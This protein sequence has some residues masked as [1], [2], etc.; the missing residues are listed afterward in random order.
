MS[1]KSRLTLTVSIALLVCLLLS[2]TAQASPPAPGDRVLGPLA[3]D[4][5]VGTSSV[6]GIGKSIDQPNIKDYQRIQE[7]MRLLAAGKDAEA[8]ALAQTADDRVLVILVEFAGTDTF[9]WNAGDTWDPLG[10]ADPNE[11]TGTVG[12]CSKIITQT[13]TFTYSGPLHNQIPRPLSADDRSGDSIWTENFSKDWFNAF[14]WG[15]GI[16]FD[17]TRQDGSKVH[18]DF[19]GESVKQYF[20]DMSGGQY[21]IAGDVIGWV[22][23]PHST[24]YYDAD[25][26]PGA[27]SGA[28]TSRGVIPGAGN[29]RT[30]VKDALD[31]VNAISNTIPGFSW[32]NYDLNGDSVIDRLWIV[33]AGYGEEDG[34]TLLNRTDYGEAAVW[35]HS[36]SVTPAYPVGEGIKAGPYIVMPE[37]GGIGVFAHEYAHNLGADDLYAYG[38]GET[39]AGFWALQADDWTGYPIGY[40]P[41]AV[42]PWHLDGWGWLN[43]KVVKDPSQVYEVTVGQASNFPGGE[44]VYRGV[45]IELPDGESPL[46]VPVWQGQHYWWGGKANLANSGMMTVA[47]IAIP[48]GGASLSFDTAYGI[49]TEWDFMWVQAS[50]DGTTWTTLTNAHTTCTHVSGWVGGN[51]GFPEDL[52]AA[53]IGGL[54]DYNHNFP[55][56]DT[57]VFDLA[58]FAG[59]SILLRFWYMTDWGTTYEGPFVDNVKVMAGANTLFADDAESGDAKWQYGAPWQRSAGM[60]PF[61]HNFY[62]QWRNVGETGGYDASLGDARW[63]FGPVNTG[64]LVWYNNNYYSD[65]EVFNYLTDFPGYGPKGRMLVVD[66]HPEPYRYPDLVAA[67]YN[68]EAGNLT[69]R[70]QMRDATFS[71]KDSITFMNKDPYGWANVPDPQWVQYP[72]R[73]AVSAFHDAWGYYPGAEFVPGGPVG[74]TSNRWMTKQWDASATMP[75]KSFY[76]IKA[77][78]YN[79]TD[80]MRFGCSTNAAGQVLC[81]S[82]AA[83]LGYTGGSGNPGDSLAQYGWHV[84]ILEQTD[85]TAKLRIWNSEWDLAGEMTQTALSSVVT[86]GSDIAVNVKAQN[87]GGMMDGFFFVPIDALTAYE[88][89]SV[90]GGAYPVTAS[91]AAS[92]AAKYGAADLTAPEG[93]AGDTVIG[94]AYEASEFATGGTVDFGFHVIV[95][96]SDGTVRHTATVSSGGKLIGTF[97][98]NPITLAVQAKLD[99]DPTADTYLQSAA[100]AANYGTAAFLH[101]R[102]D[103]AG[104]DILRS[105]LSFDVSS[106]LPAYPVEKAEL[107]VYLDAFSGGA[108]DGQLQAYEVT[109]AWAENTAT[110]KTPWVKPGGD[111]AD[112]AVAGASLDKSMVGK[113][114]TIDVTP[115]VAKWVADPASNHGVMLRLRKVSSITGYRFVSSENWDPTQWP[116]LEVTYR[117][118]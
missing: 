10:R 49:E 43:P 86:K 102:V 24:W 113:W 68:N 59:K 63:R 89:D 115:L 13:K 103:A 47:P 15:D 57:E 29:A 91:A 107:S 93:V 2:L 98:G 31:A 118:P 65:N 60:Q 16:T 109:K 79:G 84:E 51:Y 18:E 1:R 22:Q 62:L 105:L 58:A 94:V 106:I 3:G 67:G 72:G 27:R 55:E 20:L 53:G 7:R 85:S 117:K 75:A 97:T 4:V 25:Q 80:R 6:D 74:Q 110:W 21:E 8:A 112:A 42:D 26:C 61:N 48:A 38:N 44:G 46:P 39:S 69:S 41:P 108:V 9:T 50:T 71:L 100:P 14:L 114:I 111:F 116:T 56:P 17:Y 11:F 101:T 87:I 73:P 52:C 83:G 30:L 90:Y 28:S 45:K 19:M 12:D 32:K 23:V 82:Y 99:A 37:N 96:A 35:S 78:G 40:E 64:L 36:S 92:L 33:H 70:G 54:T 34:T 5:E 76:G 88:P 81:Y 104:N 66:A 95:T 77:P